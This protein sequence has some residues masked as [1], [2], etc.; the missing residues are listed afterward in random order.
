MSNVTVQT[1]NVDVEVKKKAES[2]VKKFGFSS[3]QD[4]IRIFIYDISR[5]RVD[6]GINLAFKD[7]KLEV[8]LEEVRSGKVIKLPRGKKIS[9]LLKK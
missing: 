4:V 9:E 8:A 6:L 1:R 2:V 3:L 7:Q 5:E